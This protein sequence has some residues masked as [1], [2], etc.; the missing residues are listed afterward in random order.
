MKYS[1]KI[2]TIYLIL[3]LSTCV[4]AQWEPVPSSPASLIFDI[5]EID[6]DLY[7]GTGG[8]GIYVSFDNMQSWTQI[9]NGLN[10]FEAKTILESAKIGEDLYAATRDGIYKSI[11]GENWVR[12]SNGITI[13]PGS[14]YLGT[15]SIFEYDGILM[16]GAWNGIYTSSDSAETWQITNISGQGIAPGRFF[17]H[18]GILFEARESINNPVGYVSYDGGF[19]WD[20]I[21]SLSMPTITFLSEG[22]RLWCGTI[23]GVW[24]STDDGASW[25]QRGDGLRPDPYNSSIIRA[26]GNLVTSVKF[27]GSGVFRSSDEGV[28]WHDFGEGLTFINSIEEL[29][30][31]GD[32]ILAATSEGLWQ[33][34]TLDI[35]TSIGETESALP[36]DFRLSQNYPNPFNASTKISFSLS[37]SQHVNLSVYDLLGRKMAVLADDNLNAGQYDI[38][39]DASDLASGIYF[40]R[41]DVGSQ[42]ES[43]AMVLIK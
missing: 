42:G 10:T 1:P 29:I 39:F 13:G 27:G 9:N 23:D 26:A 40:Y 38:S 18:N 6:G 12:S 36:D 22:D 21:T 4:L 15:S 7:L 14:R 25:E 43:K 28:S 41:L 3:L 5:A 20:P 16:T 33:R 35:P 32:K 2:I 34:D 11:D 19:T 24:L 31:Y 8:Q 30:I 37:K 17:N